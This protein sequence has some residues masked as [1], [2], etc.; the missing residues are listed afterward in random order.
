MKIAT[1]LLHTQARPPV[2]A[3]PGSVCFDLCSV[4]TAVLAPGARRRF[5]TGLAFAT[6]EGFGLFLYARSGMAAQGVRLA[7]GVGVV[8]SDYRGQVFIVLENHGAEPWAVRAGDR[9][10][11]GHFARLE[12]RPSF[13]LVDDLPTTSRNLGGFG[14]TGR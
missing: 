3:T 14:S 7:N 5:G 13:D 9:I 11:Q 1:T 4:E 12:S 6:P 10:A 2:F 8:D